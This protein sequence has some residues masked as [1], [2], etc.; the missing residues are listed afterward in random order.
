MLPLGYFVKG[1]LAV[2]VI[3][4]VVRYSVQPSRQNLVAL[5]LCLV[6][7]LAVLH[8]EILKIRNEAGDKVMGALNYLVFIPIAL[9]ENFHHNSRH[10]SLENV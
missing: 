6:L 4:H 1:Q 3:I 5:V 10:Y 2:V 8:Y 7:E 9:L